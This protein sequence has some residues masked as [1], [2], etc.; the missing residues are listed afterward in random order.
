MVQKS[1]RA[2][3]AAP[4]A[5][6]AKPGGLD[7]YFEITR[8]GST[9]A[10]EIRGGIVTFFSMAYIIALN[11]IILGT[12]ADKNGN[13]ISGLPA[14]GA[15]IS[16]TMIMVAG[17]TA[18]VAGLMTVLM[19]VVGR[20]PIGLA[21][22]LGLNAIAAYS[23]APTMTWPQ[24]MGLIVWEGI[25]IT[26]L[27]LTKFRRAVFNAVPR[28]LRT[29]ISVGIGLFIVL[30]GLVDAGFIRKPAGSGTTPVEL[31]IGGQLIGWPLLV[32][33][34]GL[35]ALVILHVKR[36]KGAMLIV[37]LGSTAVSLIIE[38]VVQTGAAVEHAT[39]WSLNVPTLVGAH[40]GLPDF[41]L[42]FNVDMLGAFAG[43]PKVWITMGLTILSIMLADF[44]DTMGTVVAI[45][46]EGK[47]LQA[48][49]NPPRTQEILLV[50]SVA[51]IAGG[52][53]SVSSNTSYIESASGVAEGAR[54]GLASVVTGA[55]FLLSMFITPLIDAVPS[56]AVA[57]VLVLVGFFMVQQVTEIDWSDLEVA[58]P[59][60][61][62]VTLMAFSYSITVG[63]GAGFLVYLVVK[64]VK[65][66]AKK[67]SPIL[68]TVGALFLVYFAQG[69]I[70]DWLG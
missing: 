4:S 17:A 42:L 3:V 68:W 36:V 56:E 21:A 64:I 23:L 10:A 5:S 57:P 14:D 52:L 22:G 12:A 30:I 15:N 9:V 11:P 35:F 63:I 8:R 61:F 18:L 58:L 33:I 2:K 39:G 69:I 53:G 66:K 24:V 19:G 41:S 50:D 48:D 46:Q 37:I 67:V 28:A 31:G 20:F 59:A 32:F 26:V 60:F 70:L 27:V 55:L 65:G 38:A 54:T 45:G 43:G 40:P 25:I 49:G 62:M 16:A 34:V 51:A 7:G 6:S 1:P 44:F 29:G 13:L 47:L